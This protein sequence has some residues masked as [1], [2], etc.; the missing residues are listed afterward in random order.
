MQVFGYQISWRPFWSR[1]LPFMFICG[2]PIAFYL[3]MERSSWGQTYWEGEALIPTQSQLVKSGPYSLKYYRYQ[4]PQ[5]YEAR[6]IDANGSWAYTWN[7]N[8]FSNELYIQNI[9]ESLRGRLLVY[10]WTFDA[11]PAQKIWRVEVDHKQVLGY[12]EAL[13]WYRVKTSLAYPLWFAGIC[14]SMFLALMIQI[15]RQPKVVSN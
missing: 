5:R 6:F 14:F 9:E 7:S 2:V 12:E 11:N 8:T 13:S 4:K 10:L 3:A 1:T 15:K